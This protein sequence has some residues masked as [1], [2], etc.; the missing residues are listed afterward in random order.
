MMDDYSI[1]M[2]KTVASF[3]ESLRGLRTGR[4]N[5]DY[6]N[7]VM[8]ESYGARMSLNQVAN[9]SI[10]SNNQLSVS[11]YD[12][13]LVKEAVKSLQESSLVSNVSV[14]GQVI[15]TTIPPITE[16]RRKDM[17]KMLKKQEEEYKI[18][19]RNIRKDAMN[20]VKK[21]QKDKMISEDDLKKSEKDIQNET[22][23][24][25]K[26]IETIVEK[27]EKDILNG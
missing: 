23:K 8:V 20:D 3:E 21:L 19:I 6:L 9:V 27:K 24:N 12:Q 16:E 25:I 13:S 14:A 26:L 22:D 7:S 15:M 10:V 1:I 2:K 17:I 5:G 11:V 18:R 4:V